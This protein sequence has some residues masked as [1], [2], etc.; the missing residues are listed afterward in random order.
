M[1]R[2]SQIWLS[3]KWLHHL[4][5][6]A[7]PRKP[8]KVNRFGRSPAAAVA[9]HARP[10]ALPPPLR[11]SLAAAAAHVNIHTIG[12]EFSHCH[13]SVFSPSQQELVPVLLPGGTESPAE[14]ILT[15]SSLP[16]PSIQASG[17][18]SVRSNFK[19]LLL[20]PMIL[21]GFMISRLRCSSKGARR[22]ANKGIS[23][24]FVLH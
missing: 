20:S 18:A 14:K 1:P 2:A 21:S 4:N 15:F 10:R 7:Q 11:P 22:F 9:R 17:Q 23:A 19:R 12:Q 3:A 16:P 6:S 5:V 8:R 24:E 13:R